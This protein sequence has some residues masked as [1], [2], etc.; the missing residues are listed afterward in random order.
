MD[1]EG[2]PLAGRQL[3]SLSMWRPQEFLGAA[4]LPLGA[5]VLVDPKNSVAPAPAGLGAAQQ[6]AGDP[7]RARS[8]PTQ[9]EMLL[10]IAHPWLSL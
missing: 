7:R 9:E 4:R 1:Q 6:A 3:L 8:C 2:E 5:F 10:L